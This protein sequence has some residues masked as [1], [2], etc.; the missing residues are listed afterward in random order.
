[1]EKTL[2]LIKQ[3]SELFE[4]KISGRTYMVRLSDV[5]YFE[6][7]GKKVKILTKDN[8]YEFYGSLAFIIEHRYTGF[9]QV[10][11]SYY[12]NYKFIASYTNRDVTLTNDEVIG[13]GSERKNIVNAMLLE[14]TKKYLKGE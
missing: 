13:I 11:R 7:V 6:S 2:Q 14:L 3:D 1:M 12:V 4:F 9:I 5:L 8:E 10:H